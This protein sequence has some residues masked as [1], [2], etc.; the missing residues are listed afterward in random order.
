MCYNQ[1]AWR[2]G[3]GAKSQVPASP[4]DS[5][6]PFVVLRAQPALVHHSSSAAMRQ[7]KLTV[8]VEGK[9]LSE[10]WGG[11]W[12][13][14]GKLCIVSGTGLTLEIRK[15]PAVQQMVWHKF[16]STC[17]Q[18]NKPNPFLPLKSWAS[19]IDQCSGLGLML[20]IA[21]PCL[22][23]DGSLTTL[24]RKMLTRLPGSVIIFRSSS[25]YADDTAKEDIR[26]WI[27][28]CKRYNNSLL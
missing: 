1:V 22:G 13:V 18:T 2:K 19:L 4:Q 24:W 21:N 14:L 5:R 17:N 16:D 8:F 9:K 12:D 11:V 15:H 7:K 3:N 10:S 26:K 6:V 23:L 20:N 25:D 28:H 27:K